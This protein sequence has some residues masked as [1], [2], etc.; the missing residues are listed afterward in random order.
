[1][2]VLQLNIGRNT[3]NPAQK[4]SFKGTPHELP[5]IERQYSKLERRFA[6][7]KLS[8]ETNKKFSL[9]T[10]GILAYYVIHKLQNSKMTIETENEE[11][12]A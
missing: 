9:E 1:M 2:K 6:K 4:Q 10:S 12:E 7:A 8:M 11:I 5:Q 3:R